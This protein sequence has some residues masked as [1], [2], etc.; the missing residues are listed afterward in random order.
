MKT[1][2]EINKIFADFMGAKYDKDTS[3]PMH[4]NDL[5]LPMHGICNFTGTNGKCLRYDS[6]WGWLMP[7]VEKILTLFGG[8][9]NM[10]T[11]NNGCRIYS[12]SPLYKGEL[13]LL[14]TTRESTYQAVFQFIEWYNQQQ[15]K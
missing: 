11:A 8:D 7:V 13:I 12:D 9:M 4:P 1:T 10:Y 14:N 6:S 5:W 15:E 2:Q 3:F